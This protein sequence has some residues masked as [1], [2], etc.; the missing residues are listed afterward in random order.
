VSAPRDLGG[1]FRRVWS[2]PTAPPAVSPPDG[3]HGWL[4]AEAFPVA[5]QPPA[6]GQAAGPAP[7]SSERPKRRRHRPATAPT[8]QKPTRYGQPP[9]I[10]G[11][12]QSPMERI[13]LPNH[14]GLEAGRPEPLGRL[15]ETAPSRAGANPWRAIPRESPSTSL[16][17][18]ILD[19]IRDIRNGLP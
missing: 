4:T 7:A 6:T 18:F 2:G 15:A 14:Y 10:P 8:G 16:G 3:P 17:Q 19:R 5:D 12:N 9:L 1:R 13:L 11:M